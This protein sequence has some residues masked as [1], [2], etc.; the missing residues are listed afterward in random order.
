MQ[1]Y[2]IAEKSS[3]EIDLKQLLLLVR[4]FEISDEQATG[5]ENGAAHVIATR[6]TTARKQYYKPN[7]PNRGR[8]NYHTG[9]YRNN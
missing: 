7:Q 6:K 8:G 9:G 5:I 3:C 4:S 2:K 1:L